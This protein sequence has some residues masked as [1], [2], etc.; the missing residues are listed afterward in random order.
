MSIDIPFC[1]IIDCPRLLML[2]LPLSLPVLLGLTSSFL[3]AVETGGGVFL[4]S[5]E[6]FTAA[7]F[8]LVIRML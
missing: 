7:T 6:I 8:G 3:E 2:K 5:V 1:V 4:Q